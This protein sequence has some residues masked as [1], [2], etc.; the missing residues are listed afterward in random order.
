MVSKRLGKTKGPFIAWFFF[1]LYFA[2][3]NL[4]RTGASSGTLPQN[5]TLSLIV[6]LL[7]AVTRS[8]GVV[9]AFLVAFVALWEKQRSLKDVFSSLGLRKTGSARSVFWSFVF[10]PLFAVIGLASMSLAS[11]LGYFSAWSFINEQ[12]PT[13]YSWYMVLYSFFPVAVV[14]EVWARGY[15]LD[16]LM[17]MHPLGVR[18]ALPAIL[19]SSFLFTIWHLPGYFGAYGFS[20]PRVAL[21]LSVNVF[22]ISIVLSVA[23]VRARTRNVIGPILIHFLLDA[24]PIILTLG[25]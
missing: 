19:L 2:L 16:R 5:L 13:W 23:Y 9:L 20:V 12:V 25:Q 4:L 22:P 6:N 18:R 11:S 24:M 17:P 8:Y 7:I 3:L 15:M 21:L 1:T 10:F 14:E